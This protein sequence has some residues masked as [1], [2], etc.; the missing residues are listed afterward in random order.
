[1]NIAVENAAKD[2][3]RKSALRLTSVL[4]NMAFRAE[5]PSDIIVQLVVKAEDENLYISYPEEFEARIQDLEYG[6][7]NTSPQPVLRIF[8]AR[9]AA[10]LEREVSETLFHL[11]ENM[12]V[13]N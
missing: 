8:T 13:F 9:Y 5:W 10:N 11:M 4:R 2:I 12:G 3:A 7:P 1:M 6:T